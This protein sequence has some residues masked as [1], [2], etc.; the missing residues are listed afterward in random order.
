MTEQS[1]FFHYNASFDPI[2]LM[3][4]YAAPDLRPDGRFVTNFLGVKV[5]PKFFPSILQ[6][7]EGTLE[8]I[9]IPANWHADVAEWGA[10]LRAVDLA[11]D[12]FRILEL[13][14]G[15]ACWL[16]NAGLAA[17]RR[18]LK[19]DLIGIDGDAQ[20]LG[21]AVESLPANG[22]G[23]DEYRLVHGIAAPKNGKALF[24]KQNAGE[25]DWGLQATLDPSD[26]EVE[27][28][29]ASGDHHVLDAYALADLSHGEPIDLIHVDIQGAEVDFVR[30][31]IEGLNAH[32]RHMMIGTHSREIEGRL[33]DLLLN[34]GWSLEI[35]RPAIF[36]LESGAPVVR[37]DGVQGWRNRRIAA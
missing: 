33:F 17:K 35:E 24:Q 11:H 14:C 25:S 27:Q 30:E 7:K 36:S 1:P 4:R 28:A 29:I 10:V 12:T 23:D 22:F 19:V 6:G 31:S 9:P 18:G 3:R 34:E 26:V 13:G 20:N 16:N 15:W 8:P 37:V 32:A 21:Y 2:E 5:D